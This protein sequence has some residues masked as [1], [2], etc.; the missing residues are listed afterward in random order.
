MDLAQVSRDVDAVA[1]AADL[2][3][4]ELLVLRKII[5]KNTSQHRRA[6]YFQY[7]V[8]VKRAHRAL[9]KNE[10]KETVTKVQKLLSAL[11]V[12]EGMHHV[13]WKVLNGDVK[14]DLDAALLQLR[15]VVVACVDAMEAEKKA[16]CALGAQFAMTYFIPFCVVANSLLARLFV[17]QQTMFIRCVQAHHT[18]SLAYVAQV[19]LAN[20]LRAGTTA[21]QISDYAIPREVLVAGDGP[22]LAP[23]DDDVK[24]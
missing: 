14:K 2:L 13:A 5:Y 6:Q 16:Y 10:L 3:H 12:G 23:L 15:A 24:L 4:D 9:K 17:L 8:Q 18:L 20:P 19:A 21:V 11:T 7:L 22:G 1:K